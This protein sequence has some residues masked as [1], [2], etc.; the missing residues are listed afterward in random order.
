V[1]I[2]LATRN[3]KKIE[4]I[5]RIIADLPITL[6][7]LDDFPGCPETTED[8]ATFEGNAVK[9]AEEVCRYAGK[10]ALADDSG[11]E[12]DFLDGAPGV[13]SARYAGGVGSGD[14]ARNYLK[15]LDELRDV[16]EEKRGARFVCCIALTFPDGT[17]RTF[18][19]YVEGAVS[20]APRGETGFGYDPVFVPKGRKSTFAE[21]SPDEKN[22]IS[23]RGKALDKLAEFLR[24]RPG[25]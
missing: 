5:R 3:K 10:P 23:H 22:R 6:L 12:T 9:K 2:V 16:P 1:E 21:M 8:R 18:F 25:L 11:L 4:E 13:Y 14:D 24:A 19:G 17:T 20:R 15:L 7:T